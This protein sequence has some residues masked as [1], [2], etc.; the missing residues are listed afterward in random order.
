MKLHARHQPRVNI[1]PGQT[2]ELVLTLPLFT[3]NMN[4]SINQ[5][6]DDLQWLK[7]YHQDHAYCIKYTV[8]FNNSYIRFK[9]KIQIQKMFIAIM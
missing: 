4:S 6:Q 3:L 7:M 8:H 5:G 1:D 2:T 9:F